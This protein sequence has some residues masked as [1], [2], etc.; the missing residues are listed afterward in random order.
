MSVFYFYSEKISVHFRTLV[1]RWGTVPTPP[2]RPVLP[3]KADL[4]K[5]AP[6]INEPVA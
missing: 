4:A 3:L 6:Q 2:T 1:V 5:F